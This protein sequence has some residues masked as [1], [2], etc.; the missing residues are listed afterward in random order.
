MKAQCI[1]FFLKMFFGEK[2][3]R[4]RIAAQRHDRAKERLVLV[5]FCFCFD[6]SSGI[7]TEDTGIYLK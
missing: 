7:L 4:A 6:S 3:V 2:T 5:L 1:D